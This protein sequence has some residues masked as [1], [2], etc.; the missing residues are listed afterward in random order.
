MALDRYTDWRARLTAYVAA[1][2]L[3]EFAYGRHDCALFAAGAVLAMTGQDFAAAYRGR[4]STLRGGLRVL[5]Q[6]GFADHVALA[7]AHLP[8]CH[9]SQAMPGDLAVFDSAAGRVLGVVQGQGVYVLD[10]VGR[11]VI[12]PMREAVGALRV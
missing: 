4:Y 3:P 9:P 12:V 10:Q 2:A 6:D 11:I 8:A 1:G 7:A 5:R